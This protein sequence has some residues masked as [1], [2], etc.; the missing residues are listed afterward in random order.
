MKP[1]SV[2]FPGQGAQSV[3]MMTPFADEPIVRQ[4]FAEAATVLGVDFWQA[5]VVGTAESL[6]KT[7]LTQPLLLTAGVAVYRLW[8]SLGASSPTAVAGHSLGEYCA[9]VAAKVVDF[10]TAL[11]LVSARAQLMEAS[12]EHGVGAMAAVLG[13]AESLIAECCTAAST[14]N[15]CVEMVNFNTPEQTVIAGHR[16]AVERALSML[17]EKGVKRAILLPVGGAFHSRLMQSAAKG[18]EEVL[19]QAPI[20]PPQFPIIHNATLK[21]LH[22]PDDIRAALAKQVAA[23]VKWTDTIAALSGLGINH[24]VESAPGKVLAGLNRRI[25]ADMGFYTLHDRP[26]LD[27]AMSGLMASNRDTAP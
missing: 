4:T 26:A 20:N 15:E 23:P 9:L 10:P 6:A 2:V 17:K 13:A 3:G 11:R 14:T 1:Y 7:T 16:P 19:A 12:A 21:A 27:A 25:N 8:Q 24:L 18:M 22:H 5:Q